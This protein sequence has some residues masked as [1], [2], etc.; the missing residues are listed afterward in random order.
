METAPEADYSKYLNAPLLTRSE[1]P[2]EGQWAIVTGATRFNGLGFAIAERLALEGASIVVIGTVN[3]QEIAPL[4]VQRLQAYGVAAH[5]MV[6][7]VTS[8][9]SCRQMVMKSYDLAGGNVNMLV[10]NAAASRDQ[11]IVGV[12]LE[13]FHY[14]YDPKALGAFLMSREWLSIRNRKNLRGGRIVNIGSVVGV[15]YGNYGQAAYAMANGALLGLTYDLSLEFGTRGVTVNIV[16]PTF[17]PGTEMTK[18]M[19]KDIPMI[20]ATTPNNELPTS[21]DVAGVVAWLV[22]S[23]GDHINGIVV[24]VDNNIKSNYTAIKPLT[25]AKLLS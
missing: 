23:D 18:G 1:K 22:G 3:S 25:R 17:I 5:S 20:K 8:E 24:P 10:N 4:V 11:A 19:E 16:A 13:D 7:D 15:L 12:T 14:V 21:Q 2:L 6:G 9:E